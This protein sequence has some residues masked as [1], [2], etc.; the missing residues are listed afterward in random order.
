VVQE[1]QQES[2]C[3]THDGNIANEQ[4]LEFSIKY[5]II[6]SMSIGSPP[7]AKQRYQHHEYD[8]DQLPFGHTLYAVIQQAHHQEHYIHK[9]DN[10]S[11]INDGR[12]SKA[13]A[14]AVDVV[15]QQAKHGY[16]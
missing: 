14:F 2:R 15:E 10:G 11:D 13:R 12:H 3:Q 8:K 4:G 9:K 6:T 1:R 7:D 16:G 5:S